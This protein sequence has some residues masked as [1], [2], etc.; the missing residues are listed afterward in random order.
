[1]RFSHGGNCWGALG[2]LGGLIVNAVLAFPLLPFPRG[3]A[4]LFLC[5]AS[6]MVISTGSFI[7]IREP[8]GVAQEEL[9][10]LAEQLRRGGQLLRQN[11]VF[12]RYIGTHVCLSLTSIAPPFFG[13]YAKN[14]LGAPGGMARHIR[15]RPGCGPARLQPSVGIRERPQ[16]QP[17]GAAIDDVLGN[18]LATL[19]A[20]V[21]VAAVSILQLRGTW[22]P[23]LAIPSSS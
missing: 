8:P 12:R 9:V 7:A 20:L 15:C 18:S 17:A 22:L 3:H 4:V 11:R 5:Y 16:G 2:L 10:T 23:Y 19:L 13:L 21:M 1:M 14:V 6:L